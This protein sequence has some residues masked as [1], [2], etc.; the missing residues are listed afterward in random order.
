MD[1]IRIALVGDFDPA[2]T[3]HRAIPE[4][5]RLSARRI[6]VAVEPEWVHTAAVGAAAESLAGFSGIWCVPSS[7]YVSEAGALAA[8]EWA[9]CFHRPVL[10]TCGGFQHAVLEYVRNVLGER[11]ADHA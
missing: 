8:I 4:A 9:R 6:G 5:L 2:V 10:G 1:E 3:A 11:S 7:P